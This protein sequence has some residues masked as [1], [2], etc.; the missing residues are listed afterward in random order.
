[1][2]GTH[3]HEGETSGDQ[4]AHVPGKH[5]C[6]S[7]CFWVLNMTKLIRFRRKNPLGGDDVRPPRCYVPPAASKVPIATRPASSLRCTPAH[8]RLRGPACALAYVSG[9]S[10]EPDGPTWIS[11]G[12]PRAAFGWMRVR[13]ISDSAPI[14]ANVPPPLLAVVPTW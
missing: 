6:T 11:S 3:G 4:H 8:M 10:K 9:V 7:F 5:L 1:M 2:F 12:S 13:A 14:S